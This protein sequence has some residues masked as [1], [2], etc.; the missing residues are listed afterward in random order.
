[1]RDNSNNH[2]SGGAGQIRPVSWTRT[3]HQLASHES[4]APEGI[5]PRGEVSPAS[6]AQRTLRL[7]VPPSWTQ[8]DDLP[9]TKRVPRGNQPDP[10][11]TTNPRVARALCFGCPV[12]RACLDDA[13]ADEAG[14]SYRS[15]HL[16]R[17]GLTPKGRE[18]VDLASRKSTKR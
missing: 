9:C 8:R 17:G 13:L 5:T 14:L 1:M 15:R 7:A 3:E 11:D 2:G 6:S 18:R 10:Y 4:F 12:R 16:V